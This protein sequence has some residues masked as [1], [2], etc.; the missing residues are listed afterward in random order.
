[1]RYLIAF[2]LFSLG[3]M[4]GFLIAALFTGSKFFELSEQVA[5]QKT[6]AE[7]LAVKLEKLNG[8]RAYWEVSEQVSP[9]ER[10]VKSNRQLNITTGSPNIIGQSKPLTSI[11]APSFCVEVDFSQ[12]PY[13]HKFIQSGQERFLRSPGNMILYA[14]NRLYDLVDHREVE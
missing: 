12:F 5:F 4:F 7:D 9:L 1:M 8:G 14:I 13:L 2:G 10:R 11:R 3:V 6:R